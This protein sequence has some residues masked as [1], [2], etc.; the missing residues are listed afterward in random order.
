VANIIAIVFNNV[1]LKETAAAAKCKLRLNVQLPRRDR[2]IHVMATQPSVFSEYVS[3]ILKAIKSK[4]SDLPQLR[5]LA[6]DIARLRFGNQA[7]EPPQQTRVVLHERPSEL[8]AEI[9]QAENISVGELID[10][11]L[12][13][14]L[15]DNPILSLSRSVVVPDHDHGD[16][17]NFEIDARA[18]SLSTFDRTPINLSEQSIIYDRH[19]RPIEIYGTAFTQ[20]AETNWGNLQR[21]LVLL[22]ATLVCLVVFTIILVWSDL[23]RDHNYLRPN[24]TAQTTSVSA[25][26]PTASPLVLDG[27]TAEAK[28]DV[29]TKVHDFPVPT[30]Y[31][32][33]VV[34][35]R[36]L[37]ELQPLPIRV[38]DARI[39]ISAVISN[40]GNVT[41]PNGK[42]AFII[43][44]RDLVASAP[45]KVLIRVVARVEREMK[46]AGR[47]PP[48]V[49]KVDDEW[50]IRGKSYEFGVAPFEDNAE[51]ILIRPDNA[52]FSLPPGRYALVVK[53]QGYDFTV[54]GP[55]TDPSQ[56][57]ERTNAVNETIYSEC[58]NLPPGSNH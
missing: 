31:G 36:Q 1:T 54:A 9:L 10:A 26:A 4:R 5:N 15:I 43:F 18:S 3:I 49:T 30:R 12:P 14:E 7:L 57:L 33:Y 13:T 27:P 19:L 28:S 37:Y 56:C 17:S 22:A 39:A 45:D 16:D 21:N 2:R 35:E 25:T 44:R 40:R 23:F 55:I 41:I 53:G 47:G 52:E 32:I 20:P 42:V 11:D 51:M 38:P 29:R 24:R 48:V 58:R 8:E 34:S 6:Y 46:F 50:A